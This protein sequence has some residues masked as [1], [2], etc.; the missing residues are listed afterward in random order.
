MPCFFGTINALP[1]EITEKEIL[2]LFD[3]FTPRL[4]GDCL[5]IRIIDINPVSKSVLLQD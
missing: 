2:N 5:T 4:S 1:E 3:Y